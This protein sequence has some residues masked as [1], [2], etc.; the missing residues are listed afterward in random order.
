MIYVAWGLIFCVII[1]SQHISKVEASQ[2]IVKMEEALYSEVSEETE[3]INGLTLP[4]ETD[5]TIGRRQTLVGLLSV[6][7]LLS[8]HMLKPH[9]LES[10]SIITLVLNGII[11]SALIGFTLEGYFQWNS[12]VEYSS[13]DEEGNKNEC[14]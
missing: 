6:L 7:T 10:I 1:L 3:E 12:P 13:E 5:I 4:E 11:I 14:E 9:Y 8:L 2:V